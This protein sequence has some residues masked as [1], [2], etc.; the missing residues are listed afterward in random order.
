MF[1]RANLHQRRTLA[2]YRQL[3][4]ASAALMLMFF[5]H[6]SQAADGEPCHLAGVSERVVCH[7]IEV[8][9][10]HHQPDD[11]TLKLHAAVFPARTKT[12]DRAPLVVLAG[13]PGQAATELA[14]LIRPAFDDLFAEQDLLLIDM[15]GT[16]KSFPLHCAAMFSD[17]P[18]LSD[19]W[20]FKQ[21][22]E[23][24]H[25]EWNTDTTMFS[26]AQMVQD[27]EH[28]RK[29]LGYRQLDL[30]GGS[31]GTRLGLL[32]MQ[33]YPEAVR[34]AVFGGVAPPNASFFAQESAAANGALRQVFLDCAQD[35]QCGAAYPELSARFSAWIDNVDWPLAVD[36]LRQSTGEMTTY[37]L[38]RISTV[39]M[40]RSALYTTET[41]RKLPYVLDR[42]IQG[43]VPPLF[44]LAGTNMSPDAGQMYLGMTLSVLCEEEV[45][46]IS[47]PEAARLGETS[48]AQD[49]Y[50]QY[51]LRACEG[52]ASA[53]LDENMRQPT[54]TDVPVLLLSGAL[55]PITPPALAEVAARSLPNVQHIVVEQ[56]GHN[57]A[58]YECTSGLI[59][60]FLLQGTGA[61][62]NSDC[63]ADITRP[64]FMVGPN[65]PSI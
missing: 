35:V 20:R 40:I 33:A 10:N 29:H 13:G 43:D 3:L 34:A 50:Y 18:A 24:C 16:G 60:Q 56:A 14:G 32:Y 19:P 8:P 22:I 47:G 25:A 57:I 61:P 27:L 15:R 55:D 26:S 41:S 11:Q 23:A 38:D 5:P 49:S 4:A 7:S 17:D 42:L 58:F 44:A 59:T 30:F 1:V 62:L 46:R 36:Y 2:P 6:Q 51:W 64:P 52:W 54:T 28:V 53:T 9:F 31:W 39:Q 45:R 63:T 65:G 12:P 21:A 37:Q 48:F